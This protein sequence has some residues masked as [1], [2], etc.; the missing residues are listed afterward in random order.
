MESSKEE[1]RSKKPEFIETDDSRGEEQ[2]PKKASRSSNGKK[3]STKAGKKVK[4]YPHPKKA[5]KSIEFI[6]TKVRKQK[7]GCPRTIKG[8]NT[9]FTGGEIQSQRFF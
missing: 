7:K 8:K 3:A 6:E 9:S 2:K 4:K 1:V 5:P